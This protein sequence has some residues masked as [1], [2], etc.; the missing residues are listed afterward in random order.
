MMIKYRKGMGMTVI[1]ILLAS[2]A[3]TSLLAAEQMADVDISY[4][5]RDSLRID[6]RVDAS[7]I[8]VASE[9]GIVT[10]SGTVDNLAAKQYAN[11]EAKKINGVLG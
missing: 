1:V 9:Q 8:G 7:K 2:L 3:T 10:L 5:V 4:W 11:L 6:P